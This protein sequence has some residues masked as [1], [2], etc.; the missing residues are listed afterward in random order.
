S[1]DLNL[2]SRW[3][4]LDRIFGAGESST[5]A[6]SIA[7]FAVR[8]RDFLPSGGRSHASIT[9]DQ[10]NLSR[11]VV[12][13]VHVAIER[14]KDRLEIEGVRLG[15]PGSSRAELQGSMTGPTEAPVFDGS[16]DV[17]GASLA[18]FAGWAMGRTAALPDPKGDGPF[19]VHSQLTVSAGRLVANGM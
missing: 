14:T 6:E 7:P 11:D 1:F 17:R 16:I 15:M 9:I 3:L 10:A 5:P 4:D 18:R 8:L 13:D 12:S 19:G 2:S